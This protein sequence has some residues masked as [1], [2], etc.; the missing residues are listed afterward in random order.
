[1]TKSPSSKTLVVEGLETRFLTSTGPVAAVRDVSL[2]VGKGE[3]VG[4]VGESGSGKS[5]TGLSIM[6][7]IDAPGEIFA[8]RA[9]LN[10]EDLFKA[11]PKRLRQLRGDRIA[12][13][14]QDPMMT[15]NPVLRIHTQ[16]IEVGRPRT[17]SRCACTSGNPC[18][19]RTA[20]RVSTSILRRHAPARCHRHRHA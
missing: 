6:G 18:A 10:G 12:M 8:G 14:F 2:Q 9:L 5:V 13:I 15:L 7:L 3:I 17:L 1:M 19:G 11:T 20:G 4:L 16:M